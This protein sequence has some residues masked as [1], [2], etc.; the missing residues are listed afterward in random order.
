MSRWLARR[1]AR[2][3]ARRYLKKPELEE[4]LAARFPTVRSIVRAFLNELC[5]RLGRLRGFRLT[6]ANLEV[7]NTCNLACTFCPVNQD[8]AREKGFM[9]P[10]LYRSVLERAG[11]LEWVL[12]FQWGEPL[13]HPRIFELIGDARATG[14]GVLLTTNATLLRN[15]AAGRLLRS[16]VTRVTVSVDGD[17]ETHEAVRGV[18]LEKTRAAV[19][20]LREERDR[21]GADVAIDVSMVVGRSTEKAAPLFRRSWQ[22]S[23]DRVQMIPELA[24]GERRTP[25]RELWRGAL[26]VLWDGRVTVCCADSEGELAIGNARDASLPELWNGPGM[27]ELRRA[28]VERRFPERCRR[29]SEYATPFVNPRFG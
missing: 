1:A 14:A 17:A 21:I 6:Q 25:C 13:L 20:R 28:H 15:G 11:G 18:P 16:G 3:A 5:Y 27:R 7:T 22:G 12:P 9:D 4:F 24:E 2:F 19:E 23:A 8:M 10:A 29:C 26:V